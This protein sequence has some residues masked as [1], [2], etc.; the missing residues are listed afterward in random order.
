MTKVRGLMFHANK[1][2]SIVRFSKIQKL[3]YN[4]LKQGARLHQW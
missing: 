2:E 3:N 4:L 1:W